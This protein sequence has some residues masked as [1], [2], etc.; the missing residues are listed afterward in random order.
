MFILNSHQIAAA[1]KATITN[2]N[3]S[4]LDLMEHAAKQ[5]FNWIHTRLHGHNIK[6]S[7]VCKINLHL[8]KLIKNKD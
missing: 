1:D 7:Q 5:C 6:N 3:I 8:I 4:S 2:N